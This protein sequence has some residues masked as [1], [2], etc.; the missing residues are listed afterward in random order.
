MR[1]YPL[2]I[3]I[4]LALGLPIRLIGQSTIPQMQKVDP[5]SGRSGDVVAVTGDNLDQDTVA[6]L[7]LT[8]GKE[9]VKVEIT[10]QTTTVIKFKIPANA[11]TGR[12][13]LM[14]LTRGK[15]PKLIEGPVKVLIEP[16]L[17]GPTG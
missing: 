7:Y 9:D 8:D 13:A 4:F 3:A 2:A 17:P 16:P 15:D 11:K 14:V 5:A 10:E 12:L 6:A 1:K